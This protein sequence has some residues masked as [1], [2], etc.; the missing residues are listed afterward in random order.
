MSDLKLGCLH[1]RYEIKENQLPLCC[2]LPD[3]RL[4]DA[5]PRV[6]LPIEETGIAKCPYC[7]SEFHLKSE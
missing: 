6:Y 3:Q 2:P 1:T 7:G 4:W 5:H